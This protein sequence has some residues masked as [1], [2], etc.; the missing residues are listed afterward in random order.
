MTIALTTIRK[1]QRRQKLL[2]RLRL[3]DLIHQ[4]S[5]RKLIFLCA[6]AGFGKTTL[7]IDYAEDT[8]IK[9]FLVPN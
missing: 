2:R 8:E 5:Y 9:C 6:P 7:L 4:N 1:P 3:L